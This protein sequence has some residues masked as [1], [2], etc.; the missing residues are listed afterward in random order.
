MGI[1]AAVYPS[2]SLS[3]LTQIT[4]L[5]KKK[6][7]AEIVKDRGMPKKKPVAEIVKDRGMPIFNYDSPA[8]L[9]SFPRISPLKTL[10]V[11]DKVRFD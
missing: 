9:E 2:G 8:T 5:K 1:V 10:K 11:R 3:Q 6:P 4:R 7:V